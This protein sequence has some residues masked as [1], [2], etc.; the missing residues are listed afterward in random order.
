MTHSAGIDKAFFGVD[1][2]CRGSGALYTG[3]DT[4]IDCNVITIEHKTIPRSTTGGDHHVTLANLTMTATA[5][6]VA[7][8]SSTNLVQTPNRRRGEGSSRAAVRSL[9][10]SVAARHVGGAAMRLVGFN[11]IKQDATLRRQCSCKRDLSF[12]DGR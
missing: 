10:M 5:G 9:F 4:A 8:F 6:A 11:D 3:I 2:L 12:G 7:L 1:R